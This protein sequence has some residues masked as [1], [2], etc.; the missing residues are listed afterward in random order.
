MSSS[1]TVL[2]RCDS[3]QLGSPYLMLLLVFYVTFS[4][5]GTVLLYK[6]VAIGPALAPGGLFVLPFVLLIEDVIAEVYGY[7]ISR[8]LLWYLFLSML[9]FAVIA[10]LIVKMPSPAYW[11]LQGA[12]NIV[13]DPIV[14][15]ALGFIFSLAII[16]FLNIYV[17]SK[18]KIL[19][20]GRFFWLRSIFSTMLGSIAGLVVLFMIAFYHG[21]AFITIEKLFYTDYAFRFVYAL[22]GGGPA[23]LLVIYLK[24]KEKI[25][26]YDIGTNFNPFSM[27]LT[28]KEGEVTNV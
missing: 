22:I 18:S 20:H 5:L 23:W 13:F 12:F 14:R 7:K 6:L 26:V 11:H 28:D 9:V 1:N 2:Q 24:D 21:V 19:L 25:D 8:L 17:I 4:L 3:K 16:R 15:S 10:W 27:S